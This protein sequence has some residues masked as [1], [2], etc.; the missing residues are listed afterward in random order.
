M[1]D[2]PK[3]AEE[4]LAEIYKTQEALKSGEQVLETF[5]NIIRQAQE[6]ARKEAIEECATY[7][8]EYI[9]AFGDE[10]RALLNKDDLSGTNDKV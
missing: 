1:S 4:W 8:D 7:L 6:Q 10:I 3:T 9:G 2:Q 5:K